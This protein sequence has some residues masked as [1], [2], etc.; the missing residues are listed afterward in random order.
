MAQSNKRTGAEEASCCSGLQSLLAPKL[1]KA[2]SD[3]RRIALLVRLAEAGEPCTVGAVAD[4]SGVD[5]SVVSRHLAILRE[6]GV[7]QCEK[8]GKEV[9]CEVQARSLARILRDLADALEACC[10]GDRRARG[11]ADEAAGT[12]CRRAR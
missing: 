3:P 5:L 11:G 10:P 6:A 1:F 12:R 8:Q 9:R 7:I 4:G 2:L